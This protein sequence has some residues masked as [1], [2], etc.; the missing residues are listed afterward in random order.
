MSK[1]SEYSCW[2]AN[3]KT[4][5]LKKKTNT[6]I[7]LSH[8]LLGDPLYLGVRMDLDLRISNKGDD[9]TAFHCGCACLC[10][11]VGTW[12]YSCEEEGLISTGRPLKAHWELCGF[13]LMSIHNELT[14]HT[15]SW[16]PLLR[17]WHAECIIHA[18]ASRRDNG[19]EIDVA[20]TLRAAALLQHYVL[21]ECRGLKEAE[22][23]D[24]AVL[25]CTAQIS[26]QVNSSKCCWVY[27]VYVVVWVI[28]RK[29]HRNKI[30]Q[31]LSYV[32]QFK[33]HAGPD[34]QK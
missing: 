23:D 20:H 33:G 32:S 6:L 25:N 2:A 30:L 29:A 9:L 14:S 7:K 17:H 10:K 19:R 12:A 34:Y 28:D 15:V 11:A 5:T 8:C 31:A 26:R 16:A 21:S 24:F 4:A 3:Y 18:R 1:L 27:T 13:S 22:R